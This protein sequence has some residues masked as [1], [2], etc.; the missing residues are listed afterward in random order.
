MVLI[1]RCFESFLESCPVSPLA[2]EHF[3]CFLAGCATGGRVILDLKSVAR[4]AADSRS[5]K[6][7]KEALYRG[8][9]G[10]KEF[11]DLRERASSRRADDFGPKNTRDL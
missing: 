3:V 7:K 10:V 9:R 1:T 5:E 4:R 8:A 11:L 6:R 2:N